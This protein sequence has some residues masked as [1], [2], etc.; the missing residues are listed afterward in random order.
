LGVSANY[1]SQTLNQTMQTSFFEYVNNAR[2][3]AAKEKLLNNDG[4]VLEIAMAVGFNARSSFY[5]AFKASTGMTP[6]E[7]QKTHQI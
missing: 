4:T 7:Y 6:G 2:V 1:V 3:E 5:K